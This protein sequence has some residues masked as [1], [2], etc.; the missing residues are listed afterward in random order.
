MSN[1]KAITSVEDALAEVQRIK[2]K[3]TTLRIGASRDGK[4]S[5]IIEPTEQELAAAILL[6]LSQYKQIKL[7]HGDHIA[8]PGGTAKTESGVRTTGKPKHKGNRTHAESSNDKRRLKA[9][10]YAHIQKEKKTGEGNKALAS[11]LSSNSDLTA[12]A[13]SAGCDRITEKVVKAALQA[14]SRADKKAATK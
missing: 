8:T 13:K 10:L 3:M 1:D 2:R 9:N 7:L 5:R 14:K 11:R 4:G 12:L 6:S